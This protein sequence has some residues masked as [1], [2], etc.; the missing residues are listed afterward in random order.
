MAFYRHVRAATH[1]FETNDVIEDLRHWFRSVAVVGRATY[2]IYSILG[3]TLFCIFVWLQRNEWVSL[4][5]IFGTEIQFCKIYTVFV[6][7][8]FYRL[9][10]NKIPYAVCWKASKT[11]KTFIRK[12]L[13]LG[14]PFDLHKLRRT[15]VIEVNHWAKVANETANINVQNRSLCDS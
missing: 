6:G 4:C 1:V 11:S 13:T 3:I 2:T 8:L 12:R 7:N 14:E 15:N 5:T 9:S 10:H